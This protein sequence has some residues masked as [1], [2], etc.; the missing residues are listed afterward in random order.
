MKRSFSRYGIFAVVIILNTI[1]ACQR[2]NPSPVPQIQNSDQI[3]LTEP[4]DSARFSPGQSIIINGQVTGNQLDYSFLKYYLLT[5]SGSD[6]LAT[7]NV[8]V[9]GSIHTT[10]TKN[11]LPG[12]YHIFLK[13]VNKSPDT[14]TLSTSARIIYVDGPPPVILNTDS[15]KLTTPAD[16]A[17]FTPGQAIDIVGKVTG[18]QADYSFLNYYVLTS[19]ANDTL[20]SGTV[21]ADGSIQTTVQKNLAAGQYP[22]FL[23]AVNKGTDTKTLSSSTRLIFVG[24]PGPLQITGFI[25]DDT[26]ITVKWNKS[27]ASNFKSYQVY[28]S[29]TDTGS[30]TPPYALGKLIA[31]ITDI[32][33]TTA[34]DNSVYI[35]YQYR[36]VVRLNTLDNLYADSDPAVDSAGIFLTLPGTALPFFDK[37]R[38]RFYYYSPK[39]SN[40]LLTI[41]PD[42]LSVENATDIGSDKELMGI[43]ETGN[44]LNLV[45]QQPDFFNLTDSGQL[46]KFDLITHTLTAGR[47]FHTPSAYPVIAVSNNFA[48]FTQWKIIWASTGGSIS[49]V[50]LINKAFVDRM[51]A[52]NNNADF[53]VHFASNRQGDF[54]SFYVFHISPGLIQQTFS[55]ISTG[56]LRLDLPY[57][58]GLVGDGTSLFDQ[59]FHLKTLLPGN[60][61][62][63]GISPDERFVA[64]GSNQIYR[65]SD[66]SVAATLGAGSYMPLVFFRNDGAKIYPVV[67]S[68]STGG[69]YKIYRYPWGK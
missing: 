34:M 47:K 44:S 2:S 48:F 31:T 10:L 1:N 38:N 63:T 42:L 54:D 60:D 66:L 69:P 17:R 7:G 30:S 11:P 68:T 41:N 64:G 59:S 57:S 53:L 20:A 18:S 43:D 22:I 29:R 32:N 51:Q 55:G 28:V 5:S 12:Q 6:T 13:A 4:A 23:K 16:S 19:S 26:S 58:T 45:V 21:K 8:L 15:I 39:N 27:T 61:Y 52:F 3:S 46:F 49:G 50:Q 40:L 36:Y 9:D 56:G 65:I 33:Q 14:K 35:G 25:N 67:G 62:V 37:A 24:A